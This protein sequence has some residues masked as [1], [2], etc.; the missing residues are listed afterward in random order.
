MD[1]KP[2]DDYNIVDH[3]FTVR[4]SRLSV[5]TSL[6]ALHR[7]RRL[8]LIGVASSLASRFAFPNVV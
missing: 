6:W 4:L 7:P 3:L 2:K 8:K 1:F 5:P